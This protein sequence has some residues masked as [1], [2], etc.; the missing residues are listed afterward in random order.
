MATSEYLTVRDVRLFL[1]DRSPEDNEAWL[2]VVHSDEEIQDAM[3]RAAR[4]FNSVLPL[5][6]FVDGRRLPADTELFLHAVKEQVLLAALERERRNDVAFTA[7]GVD[8]NATAT[9]IGHWQ[10][11][12]Q[13][14]H[15][16][17]ATTAKELKV[18]RNLSECYGA[19]G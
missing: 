17:W 18:A 8:Y 12:I 16:R 10:K 3:T 13:E 5:T 9:R 14:A 11:A 19:I 4:A 1:L 15:D 7:G 6:I 2:D